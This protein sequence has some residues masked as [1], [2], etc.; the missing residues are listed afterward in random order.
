MRRSWLALALILVLTLLAAG[1]AAQEVPGS[2]SRHSALSSKAPTGPADVTAEIREAHTQNSS[3]LVIDDPIIQMAVMEALGSETNPCWLARNIRQDIQ[4]HLNYEPAGG[5]SV[6][7]TVQVCYLDSCSEYSF[8]MPTMC[9]SPGVP[10]RCAGS[11]IISID[12]AGRD[13]DVPTSAAG[14]VVPEG[15][16]KSHEDA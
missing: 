1:A 16:M 13:S 11:V 12:N 9:H 2:M 6:A 3:N 15:R 7:S 10:A 4:D 5:W 14:S 8:V